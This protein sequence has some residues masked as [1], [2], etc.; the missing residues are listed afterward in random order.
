[1]VAENIINSQIILYRKLIGAWKTF[2]SEKCVNKMENEFN[3]ISQKQ[4]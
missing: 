3:G 4:K 2:I 1:L